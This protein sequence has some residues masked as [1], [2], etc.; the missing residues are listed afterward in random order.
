[1][2]AAESS[3]GEPPSEETGAISALFYSTS[4]SQVLLYFPF[5]YNKKVPC[6]DM[7]SLEAKDF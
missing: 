3:F 7:H 4:N 6:M 1:M 5:V 2:Y